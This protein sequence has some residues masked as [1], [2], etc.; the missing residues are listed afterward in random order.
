LPSQFEALARLLYLKLLN[1]QQNWA[2]LLRHR[3]T[4]RVASLNVDW[5]HSTGLQMPCAPQSRLLTGAQG[6]GFGRVIGE[7]E[8]DQLS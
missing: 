1:W 5:R 7:K 6:Q 8:A 2:W 3:L 4:A